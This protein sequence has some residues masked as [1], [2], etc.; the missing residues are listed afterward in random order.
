MYTVPVKRR[1]QNTS[2]FKIAVPVMVVCIIVLFFI[3]KENKISAIVIPNN[4]TI[5]PA[6]TPERP[7]P[8]KPPTDPLPEPEPIEEVQQYYV[9]TMKT[10]DA[11]TELSAL[12][13]TDNV[14]AVLQTNRIDIDTIKSGTKIVIP[15]AFDPSSRSPF[16]LELEMATDI[17]KL[18][19]IDQRVQ[20]FG[21]YESGKLVRW[22]PTSTGKQSTKTP[23]GLFSTNWK[24]V[25][26][27]SSFDDEWLL[28]YNF[29]IDNF[30]GISFHQYAMPGYPASHSCVRLLLEDAMWLYEW[31]DQWILS[32]DERERLAHGTPVLI[33][34]DYE[35]DKTAPWKLL[36]TDADATKVK[37]EE[38]SEIIEKYKETIIARQEEREA[39]LDLHQE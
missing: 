29:N 18:L 8:I 14:T 15:N 1:K 2:R 23:N 16:P 27:K 7:E 33:F 3:I 32:T 34:D 9:H 22:G 28:K 26:V 38:L 24:G 36:P 12:V 6:P 20:A 31:A 11:Q 39:L 21:T 5:V 19:V 35:F 30:E 4:P 10:T 17:T 37:E 13:G 25:E